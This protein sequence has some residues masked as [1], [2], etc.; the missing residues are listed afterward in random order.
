MK[1]HTSTK[2]ALIALISICFIGAVHAGPEHSHAA[3]EEIASP[4]GGRV[5]TVVEPHFEFWLRGDRV[6]QITFIDDTGKAIPVGAQQISLV[7]GSR[8]DPVSF[9]F[10]QKSG[11]LV[12][13]GPLPE[14]KNMPI[15]LQIKAAPDSKKV[16]EKFYLNLSKCGSCSYQEYAC[17]CGH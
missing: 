7:G 11:V 3:L 1:I 8:S 10:V 5:V 17:I 12:S 14:I 4:N 2:C 15:V 13:E 6:A 9:N 16:R